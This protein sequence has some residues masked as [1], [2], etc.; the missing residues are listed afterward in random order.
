MSTQASTA[1]AKVDPRQ[2]SLKKLFEGAKGA[3]AQVVPRH[4]TAD[5]I[6]KVTLSATSRTPKLLECTQ[7]SILQRVMQA[8]Q[9]GLE[10]GGPLGHAYLVPF[11][12][13]G[14]MECSMIVGY[15]GLIDLAR[16]SGQIDSIEARIV[17]ERDKFKISYGLIQ[18]LEHEPF[19]DGH[20]GKIVAV[21]AIARIK[22]S[23]PQV[24]MMTRDQVDEIKAMSKTAGSPDSPWN[25]H[26]DEMARKTVVRRICKYLPLSVELATAL[27]ADETE[28]DAG[29]FAT[30]QVESAPDDPLVKDLKAKAE[31][32]RRNAIPV[33]AESAPV[34]PTPDSLLIYE[35]A[36]S[37]AENPEQLQAARD[38]YHAAVNLGAPGRDNLDRIWV[39]RKHELGIN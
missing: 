21:Y 34:G 8:A 11:K 1:M 30:I 5:R 18:V 2:D 9:L 31:A 13:K 32:G 17:C 14:V 37:E 20:P 29:A 23:L 4:L 19:M 15:K 35:A 33:P 26:F 25:L 27:E 16:R 22:N 6:L 24:E 28:L 7:M 10:P 12:N 38:S 36:L 3:I 39:R